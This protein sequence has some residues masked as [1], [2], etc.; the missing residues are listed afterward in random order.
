M[1]I[2]VIMQQLQLLTS[3]LNHKLPHITM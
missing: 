1:Y 3:R 2:I